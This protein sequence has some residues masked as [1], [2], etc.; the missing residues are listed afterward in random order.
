MVITK[1]VNITVTASN[2]KYFV[3]LGYEN[4]KCGLIINLPVDVVFWCCHSLVEVKCDVCKKK[5]EIQLQKSKNYHLCR[6]CKTKEVNLKK[7]GVEYSFQREDIKEKMKKNSLEKYGN[8]YYRNDEKRKETCLKKYGCESPLGNKELIKKGRKT[9]LE[10][11][12][13]EIITRTKYYVDEIRKIR[14]LQKI[15]NNED[16][17]D[18][19]YETNIVKMICD[20][21]HEFEID[22]CNYKNRKR[23]KTILCTI[24][25]PLY[26]PKSGYENQLKD[27]IKEN[28]NGEIIN[29]SRKI[30]KPLELDI[31][32]PDLKLAFEFNGE[33]WHSK[34]PENYHEIKTKMCSDKGIKLIHIGDK[35][36]IKE[37]TIIKKEILKSI[38]N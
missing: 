20:K 7:Y 10:K 23:I 15:E 36:W 18:V 30:I 14:R 34:R 22:L 9:N 3:S 5:Y 21:D 35:E 4:I 12:G 13:N 29:N 11:Y 26:S 6:H 8:E 2:F 24:C 31:Y 1:N 25:N 38:I 19:N 32:L 27:F 33:Y 37:N 16:V 17:I 28:Y